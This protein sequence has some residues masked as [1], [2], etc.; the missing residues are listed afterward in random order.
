MVKARHPNKYLLNPGGGAG[1]K[2]QKIPL[3]R[4][5]ANID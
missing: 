2:C 4:P 1:S 3:P 5:E